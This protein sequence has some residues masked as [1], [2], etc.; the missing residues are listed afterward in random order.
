M[1]DF[2]ARVTTTI[3]GVVRYEVEVFGDDPGVYRYPTAK[4]ANMEWP[5]AFDDHADNE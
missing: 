2:E 3:R 5:G 4:A 1:Q